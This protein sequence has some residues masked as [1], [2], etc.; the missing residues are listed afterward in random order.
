LEITAPGANAAANIR[1]R[2]SDPHFRRRSCPVINVTCDML[3]LG[4]VSK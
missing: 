4:L 2:S 1:R 3:Y